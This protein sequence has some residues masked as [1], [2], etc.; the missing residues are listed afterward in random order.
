MPLISINEYWKYESEYD[1]LQSD[2]IIHLGMQLQIIV[3][4]E[5]IEYTQYFPISTDTLYLKYS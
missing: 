4:I 1:V 2:V 5:L 3:Y